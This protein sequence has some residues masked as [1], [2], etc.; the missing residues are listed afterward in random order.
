[1][2]TSSDRI[3]DLRDKLPPVMIPN[4]QFDPLIPKMKTK[5]LYSSGRPEGIVI[6]TTG[7]STDQRP[8]DA[9]RFASES[10]HTYL[11]IDGQGV[12]WQ[13]FNLSEW[14]YHAG[15]SKCPATGRKSVSR[16]YI[17]IEIMNPGKLE[18]KNHELH[19]W[20]GAKVGKK[21]VNNIT[22]DSIGYRNYGVWK[23]ITAHQEATLLNTC[24]WLCKTFGISRNLIFGH[25]E[26]SPGRKTD[27]GG[28]LK[29]PMF[30]LRD[31]IYDHLNQ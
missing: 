26:V 19:T 23:I 4:A 22:M 15:P 11:L 10:G 30:R 8:S 16:H 21:G 27:P 28:A 5:G 9:L 20:Y 14:G 18:F 29:Y 13:Q 12:L 24:N 31:K 7:G 1:M 2:F 6:H 3:E 17:G 25:D